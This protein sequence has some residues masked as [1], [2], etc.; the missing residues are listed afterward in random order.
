[1][2]GLAEH[3]GH[4]TPG[5]LQGLIDAAGLKLIGQLNAAPR[6]P[7][8]GDPSKPFHAAHWRETSPH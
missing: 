8:A 1:M 4:R 2:A 7:K 6:H 3:L 5:E